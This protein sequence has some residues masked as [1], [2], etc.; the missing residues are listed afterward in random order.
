MLAYFPVLTL[1]NKRTVLISRPQDSVSVTNSKS[2]L[3]GRNVPIL[4]ATHPNIAAVRLQ[5]G[6]GT[7]FRHAP[8]VQ[9]ST[10]APLP[11]E[12]PLPWPPSPED[13]VCCHH[14]VVLEGFNLQSPL[15]P[16]PAFPVS[17]DLAVR[18]KTVL[19][20]SSDNSISVGCTTFPWFTERDPPGPLCSLPHH[21]HSLL[22]S[23]LFT[24]RKKHGSHLLFGLFSI[25]TENWLC[26]KYCSRRKHALNITSKSCLAR[27]PRGN[28][29]YTPCCQ[30]LLWVRKKKK[31]SREVAWGREMLFKTRKSGKTSKRGTWAKRIS[32]PSLR[33]R[34][35][36]SVCIFKDPSPGCAF[37]WE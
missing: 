23:L 10:R 8:A 2:T 29:Q 5:N 35:R 17:L 22:T 15:I 21:S 31:A 4:P 3:S 16:I 14:V 12:I 6:A 26:V 20:S 19:W 9:R 27:R 11:W 34:S 7:V 24:R 1:A 13:T 30:L 25:N 32:A 33:L 28:K 18:I 37:F 36:G